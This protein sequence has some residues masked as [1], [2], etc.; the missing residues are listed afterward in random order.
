M[1][2][3]G[4]STDLHGVQ[5]LAGLSPD[6]QRMCTIYVHNF[7]GFNPDTAVEDIETESKSD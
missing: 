5:R 2:R 6:P 1:I 3:I 7:L 4:M